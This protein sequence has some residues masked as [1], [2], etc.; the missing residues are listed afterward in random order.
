MKKNNFLTL[1]ALVVML[2]AMTFASCKSS[3]KPATTDTEEQD[4]IPRTSSPAP[5]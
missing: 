4:S 5:V 1:L 2:A 3:N